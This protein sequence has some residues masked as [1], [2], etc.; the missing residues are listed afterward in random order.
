MLAVLTACLLVMPV[1]GQVVA[2]FAPEGAFG[3]HWG[4]D[5]AADI[6]TIV[7]APASGHVT[8]AGTVAGMKTVSIGVDERVRVSV[9]YLSAIAVAAGDGV[10]TGMPI[11]ATGLAH[12][13]EALHLSVRVGGVY[14]DPIPFF[15]CRLDIARGLW[16]V[17][18]RIRVR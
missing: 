10:V 13:V 2:G 16:L 8:F 6:G 9:S 5:V 17:E 7:R 15:A 1:S 14:V 12:G 18:P 11:G 3:G 4:I